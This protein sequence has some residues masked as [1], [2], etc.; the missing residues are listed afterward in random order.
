MITARQGDPPVPLD[1]SVE[2]RD[3]LLRLAR[4]A[5]EAATG[6]GSVVTLDDALRAAADLDRPAA[7]FVTLTEAGELRGCIGA[8]HPDR[9]LC[10]AVVSGAVSAAV[11]DPRFRPVEADELPAIELE[12]SVLGSPVPLEDPA[13]FRPGVDGVIV[14]RRGRVAILLPEVATTL[15]WGTTEMLDAVCSKAGLPRDAWRDVGTRLTRFRTTRFGGPAVDA[16]RDVTLAVET[17]S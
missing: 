3:R 7:V 14:E 16:D 9:A 13:R 15:G 11:R 10:D 8:I 2:S 6:A 4:A 12:I 5:L 1:L 17:G